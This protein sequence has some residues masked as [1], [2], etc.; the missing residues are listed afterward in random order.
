MTE[1]HLR[2]TPKES[3]ILGLKRKLDLAK[4][5][6][7]KGGRTSIVRAVC[8]ISKTSAIQL[9]KEI[10]GHGPKA[11]LL[12]YDPDW[13]AKSPEN[14]LHASI[15]FNIF[16]KISKSTSACK[17][18]IYLAAYTLYEQTLMDKPKILNINRTWH[19]GQQ[20]SMLYICGMECSRC[21]STYVAIRGFPDPY[22]F[23]PLC[24]VATDSTGQQKWKQLH[25]RPRIHRTKSKKKPSDAIPLN[26]DEL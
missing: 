24:D 8:Q 19:V 9:H 14:C 18:E 13:I 15:Y 6:I 25:T 26:K 7:E 17:E 1:S 11:G 10:H 4:G 2:L 22:K 12:P 23:C 3:D 20:I 16:Q 5:I 21:Y